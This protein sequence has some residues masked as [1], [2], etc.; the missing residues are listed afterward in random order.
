MRNQK[1]NAIWVS[2]KI[3]DLYNIPNGS[4]KKPVP[5]L[6]DTEKYVIHYE[7][8]KFYLRLGMKVKNCIGD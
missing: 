2:I 6:F 1:W 7:N 4:V 5:N 8:F 3:A